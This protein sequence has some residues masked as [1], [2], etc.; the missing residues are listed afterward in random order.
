MAENPEGT[1]CWPVLSQA[2]PV[3]AGTVV[4]GPSK[5]YREVTVVVGG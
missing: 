2:A 4:T 3:M 1:S 5:A